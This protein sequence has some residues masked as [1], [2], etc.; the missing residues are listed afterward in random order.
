MYFLDLRFA[1]F[2]LKTH[3]VYRALGFRNYMYLTSDFVDC[4]AVLKGV[5]D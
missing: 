2:L 4:T 3:N 5:G 1:V